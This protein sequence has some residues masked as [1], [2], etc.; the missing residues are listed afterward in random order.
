MENN[1]KCFVDKVKGKRRM[2]WE[3]KGEVIV[4]EEG[5]RR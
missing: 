1:G 3:D 2:K 5:R 4:K